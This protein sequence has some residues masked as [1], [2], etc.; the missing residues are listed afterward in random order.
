MN[1]ERIGRFEEEELKF[2]KINNY[3][4]GEGCIEK[5]CSTLCNRI[6][7]FIATKRL[8]LDQFSNGSDLPDLT[9]IQEYK[10]ALPRLNND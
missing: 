8:L 3:L 9:T 6:M 7:S 4:E 10:Q 1:F 5:G 2:D